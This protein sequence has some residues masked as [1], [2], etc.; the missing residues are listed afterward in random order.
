MNA[1]KSFTLI[2]ASLALVLPQAAMGAPAPDAKLWAGTWHLSL[3]KSKFSSSEFTP[4][5]ETRTYRVSANRLTMRS[6]GIG[7]S[8]KP[9]KWS[10]T[11]ATNGKWYPTTGNPNTDRISLTLVSDRE[12]T[13]QTR[14]K[15]K[16]S[17]KSTATV[18]AGGNSAR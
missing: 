3:A 1:H 9:M 18:A 10:Y 8:G 2:V 11:A 12:I 16:P 5:S 17:A 4:K 6:S 15:G 13:S 7:A 14:L